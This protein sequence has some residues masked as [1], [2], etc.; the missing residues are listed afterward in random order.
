[1]SHP[2][3][4][5][6]N[7]V[8][9]SFKSPLL[10]RAVPFSVRHVP[11]VRNEEIV[12]PCIHIHRCSRD[13]YRIQSKRR[14]IENG[15]LLVGDVATIFSFCTYKTIFA[16]VL[17]PSFPG[18]MAP[19]HFNPIRFIE[20]FSFVLTVIGTWVSVGWLVDAYT[21]DASSS[22]QKSIESTCWV[23]IIAMPITAAQLV[24]T[25][26]VEDQ[27][28]VGVVGWASKVPLAASGT[29][30]PWISAAGILTVMLV[31]RSFYACYLDIWS[32][33]G[34]RGFADK[35][36]EQEN[37]ASSLKIV[38][39]FVLVGVLVLHGLSS[40]DLNMNMHK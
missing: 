7:N 28:L 18:W 34:I 21:L 13:K 11:R 40:Q 30:E 38:I 29:L 17:L 24:L 27:S 12:G 31:W 10:P 15:E 36:K 23:W 5:I 1:M 37:F 8:S 2:V 35:Q 6:L 33:R 16:L 20:Y 4:T 14:G 39:G 32:F 3:T 26:A 19:L 9:F 22:L 25:T